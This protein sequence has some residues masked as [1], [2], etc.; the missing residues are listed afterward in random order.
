MA[1]NKDIKPELSSIKKNLKP[2]SEPVNRF[3]KKPNDSSF[4]DSGIGFLDSEEEP[5]DC[6]D[7]RTVSTSSLIQQEETEELD[8]SDDPVR[9]YL[10][11]MGGVGLLS[12][13]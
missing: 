9:V 8:S 12:R 4:V 1:E 3:K 7:G 13:G 10:R 6:G 2:S 5:V 11:D